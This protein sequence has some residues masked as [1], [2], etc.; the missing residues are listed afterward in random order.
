M[1]YLKL[2]CHDVLQREYKRAQGWV[3]WWLD[4][5]YLGVAR[6]L[7]SP[8]Q[9]G[10]GIHYLPNAGYDP[11]TIESIS[12]SAPMGAYAESSRRLVCAAAAQHVWHATIWLSFATCCWNTK[13]S[14]LHF[15]VAPDTCKGSLNADR[16]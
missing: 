3:C 5:G 15:T 7:C 6:E 14:V 11:C 4:L 12:R 1:V 10:R 13:L 8:S 16:Q 2:G 9:V